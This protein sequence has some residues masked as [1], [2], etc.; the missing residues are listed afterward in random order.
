[1][2]GNHRTYWRGWV[3]GRHWC[4]KIPLLSR[5]VSKMMKEE[6]KGD[7]REWWTGGLIDVNWFGTGKSL[8][9]SSKQGQENLDDLPLPRLQQN[10]ET[11]EYTSKLGKYEGSDHDLAAMLERDVLEDIASLNEAK[12]LIEEAM[13]IHDRDL[14]AFELKTFADLK[15]DVLQALEA[16]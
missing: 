3:V 1:M 9:E 5:F 8:P 15:P 12:R 11:K 7:G 10:G 13:V 14:R 16:I 2:A 4:F 6:E